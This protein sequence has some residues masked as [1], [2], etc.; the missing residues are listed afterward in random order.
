M[1]I[2]KGRSRILHTVST[3]FIQNTMVLVTA[4]HKHARVSTHADTNTVHVIAHLC[5][6]KICWYKYAINI[7]IVN[8]IRVHQGNAFQDQEHT[9]T[10]LIIH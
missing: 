3:E 8:N 9:Q 4:I 5:R 7:N 6:L 1:V 10:E 2:H